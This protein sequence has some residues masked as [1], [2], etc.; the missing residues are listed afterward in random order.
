MS[1]FNK[2]PRQQ[3]GQPIVARTIN[4]IAA[5]AEWSAKIKA[6]PP[7]AIINTGAGPLL[8]LAG[9]IFG[10]YI[11]ITDGTITARVGTSP[12]SGNVKIQTWNGSALADLGVDV[13]VLSIS[14]TTGG[15]ATGVYVIVLRILGAYWLISV[16][17]AN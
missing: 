5:S 9:P 8:R 15:I 10:V 17:C 2:L 6:D 7:L 13:P 14:S 12:G 11:G 16:D 1:W 4:Q 3:A